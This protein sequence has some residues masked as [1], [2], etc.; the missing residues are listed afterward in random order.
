MNETVHSLNDFIDQIDFVEMLSLG[1]AIVFRGQPVKGNLLP[2]IAR[3]NS[4]VDMK[5]QEK[6]VLAQLRLQGAS[7]I[8][9]ADQSDL[10]LLV[11]AQHYGLKTRL[12]DWTS[13][14]L[15]ALWFACSDAREGDVYVYALDVYDFLDKDIY[16][17]DPYGLPKTR[18]FQ[19]RLNNPRIV[20]Q[21]GWFT[22]HSFAAKSR[23]FVA[24]E[25]NREIKDHLHEYRINSK[26]RPDILRMLE[27]LGISAKTMFPSLG[28][29]CQYFN[30]KL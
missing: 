12:L 16:S 3:T 20:A 19:P 28:G 9:D 11:L 4:N 30:T 29:L 14:P 24:L 17:K 27:R 15:A 1:D 8:D 13:N 5:G 10:D 6:D 7:L 22:L 18:L 2:R 21:Q 26:Q 25:K 23:R